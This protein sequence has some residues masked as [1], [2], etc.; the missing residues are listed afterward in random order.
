MEIAMIKNLNVFIVYFINDYRRNLSEI[1]LL[2][3]KLTYSY[4]YNS[5]K[6][7]C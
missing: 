4:L 2:Q 3:L 6:L 5:K 7:Y 1:V